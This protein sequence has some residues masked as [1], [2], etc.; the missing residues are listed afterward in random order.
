M[1]GIDPA[2]LV[3]FAAAADQSDP[4]AGPGGD[5]ATLRKSFLRDRSLNTSRERL[6]FRLLVES[7]VD[8]QRDLEHDVTLEAGAPITLNG[9]RISLRRLVSNLVDNALKYG[10]RARLRLRVTV[11]LPDA[12]GKDQ[13]TT[14]R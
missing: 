2:G 9:N 10:E 13:L 11:W 4:S 6:D 12:R 8:D 5:D 14:I 1:L 7:I 3:F